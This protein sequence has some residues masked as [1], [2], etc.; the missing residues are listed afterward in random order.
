MQQVHV[1]A[2]GSIP[3]PA[4]FPASAGG[5]S[6]TLQPPP[7][8]LRIIGRH[9]LKE[10][11]IRNRFACSQS[12]KTNGRNGKTEQNHLG[13][14]LDRASHARAPHEGWRWTSGHGTPY[15]RAG[16]MRLAGSGHTHRMPH[17]S[18]ACQRGSVGGAVGRYFTGGS[19]RGELAVYDTPRTLMFG[20]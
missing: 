15:R 8:N 9:S 10:A 18:P 2:G 19:F 16:E 1:N 12:C 3:P 14:N 4:L 20:G 17:I 11:L 5:A 7:P 13:W 6:H